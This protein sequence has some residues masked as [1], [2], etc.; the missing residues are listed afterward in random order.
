M[1]KL[2]IATAII[3]G[4]L[5]A[6]KTSK[7]TTEAPPK[8]VALDCTT[9]AFTYAVDIKPIME[10]YCTGCH[11]RAG[12]YNFTLTADVMRAAKNGALLGTIKRQSGFPQM[13]P[14]AAQLDATVI[15]K[16]ECW[17]NNGMKE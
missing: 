2:F 17:I 1:K 3:A 8:P 5:A 11:G 4:T 12:G 14:N 6:C 9:K 7:K 13:P 16:I 15:A 10:Q